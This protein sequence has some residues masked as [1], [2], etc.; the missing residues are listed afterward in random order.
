MKQSN[1]RE[2]Y[3]EHIRKHFWWRILYKKEKFSPG[4]YGLKCKCLHCHA[5]YRVNS[6]DDYPVCSNINN[7]CP[8]KDNETLKLK[9]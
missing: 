7:I 9:V 1:L 3:N 2:W 8:C 5:N 4:W 6:T